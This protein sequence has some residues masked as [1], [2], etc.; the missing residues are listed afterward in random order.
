MSEKK[1][2]PGAVDSSDKNSRGTMSREKKEMDC[3]Y[4]CL[5]VRDR[6]R[7][8]ILMLHE[9]TAETRQSRLFVS[10]CRCFLFVCK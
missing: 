6:A 7:T 10:A 5:C 4:V 1:K 8:E 2:C 3:V 9:Q